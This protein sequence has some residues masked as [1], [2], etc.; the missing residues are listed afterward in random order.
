MTTS[1]NLT[2][3]LIVTFAW[4]WGFWLLPV[5]FHRGVALPPVLV[6]LADGRINPAAWGPLV[7]ALVSAFLRGGVGGVGRLLRRGLAFRFEGRWYLVVVALFP[8]LIGGAMA[9]GLLLGD[10]LPR[11]EVLQNPAVIPFAFVWI[12][13]LG[14]PLQEEFGWRGTLQDPLQRRFGAF[15]ASLVVGAIWG[16]WHLPLFSIPGGTIYYDRPFAGLLVTSMMISVLFGWVWNN[17]GG[18]VAAV[19]L[20]HTMFNLS[21]YVFPML[22]MD[23]AALILFALQAGVIGLVVLRFGASRLSR[24]PERAA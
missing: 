8:L 3:F 7:G 11:L 19:L 22:G 17:T 18:S 1:R 9:L 5:L 4:S 6:P 21:H 10:P 24:R 2:I 14:G 20:L 16:L 15:W 13:F 12:L 23:R